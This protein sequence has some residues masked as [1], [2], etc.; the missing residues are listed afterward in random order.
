M[1]RVRT[2]LALVALGTM[3]GAL[4]ASAQKPSDNRFTRG[5]A[6]YLSQAA[7][8]PTPA[9]KE[10]LYE[11]G[12]ELAQEGLAENQSNPK[13]YMLLG[14]AYAAL[15]RTGEA[16][17]AWDRALELYPEYEEELARD[18][19]NAWI[20]SYNAGVT[21][22]Q[23]GD[24]EAAEEHYAQADR[25]FG[26]RPEA[27]LNLGTLMASQGRDEEAISYFESALEIMNS[28]VGERLKELDEEAFESN[29]RAAV[30]N[31]AQV[32]A[33]AGREEEAVEAYRAHL[34][35]SPQDMTAIGNLG[36]VLSQLGRTDEVAELYGGALDRDDLEADD[37]FRLGVGLFAAERYEEAHTAFAKSLERNPHSRDA[38]Y[39][40]A[41]SIYAQARSLED[42]LVE[43]G[44]S[45]EGE[46]REKLV[47]YY[48]ELREHTSRLREI[49][50]NHEGILALS[51]QAARSLSDLAPS[52][53]AD[54]ERQSTADLLQAR[55]DLV[56][57]VDDVDMVLDDDFVIVSGTVTN[58]AG[59]GGDPVTLR[60]T[61]V[62]EEGVELATEDVAVTLPA[63][64]ASTEWEVELRVA[65]GAAPAGWRYEVVN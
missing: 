39:N 46:T 49:D 10:R 22:A 19:Q 24:M 57:A 51:A 32:L 14:R 13:L 38:R 59:A 40:M 21:A 36:V 7:Q 11:Q 31:L 64:D 6:L 29:R 50:P 23:Q 44:E 34:E 47:G 16:A 17:D 9:D 3:A 41:N 2:I 30:F 65:E 1:S 12:V 62:D 42:G 63:A 45:P 61:V 48:T 4:P 8:A 52:G 35:N 53:S 5:V 15:S 26:D 20:R 18:R 43:A 58:L 54:A 33:R 28:E 56:F 55:Q 37:Y 27:K 25:V 60:L